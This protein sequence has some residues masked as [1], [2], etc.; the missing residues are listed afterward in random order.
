MY[1]VLIYRWSYPSREFSKV[2]ED[3]GLYNDVRRCLE[4]MLFN[5]FIYLTMAFTV[6]YSDNVGYIC[7]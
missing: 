4:V 2:H 6:I 5:E 3:C 7:S 1:L